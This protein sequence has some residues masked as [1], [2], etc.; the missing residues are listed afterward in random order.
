MIM[1]CKFRKVWGVMLKKEFV[2]KA[3]SAVLA[4]FFYSCSISFVCSASVVKWLGFVSIKIN[5]EYSGTEISDTYSD[6]YTYPAS[7]EDIDGDEY[8][9]GAEYSDNDEDSD[10][11]EDSDYVVNVEEIIEE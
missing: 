11:D 6:S 4:I 2:K 10:S 1:K 8:L 9:D 7:D 5:D 3:I